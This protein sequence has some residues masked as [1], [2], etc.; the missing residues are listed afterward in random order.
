MNRGDEPAYPRS[1]RMDFGITIREWW[2]AQ[3]SEEDIREFRAYPPWEHEGKFKY[4]IKGPKYTRVQ[5]RY[6][7]ADAMLKETK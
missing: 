5:A 3:A 4:K 6:R 2:A 7:F 1:G